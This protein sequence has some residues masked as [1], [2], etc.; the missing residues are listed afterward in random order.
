MADSRCGC[1]VLVCVGECCSLAVLQLEVCTAN[2]VFRSCNSSCYVIA[3]LRNGNGVRR[4]GFC[5]VLRGFCLRED[6]LGRTSISC[7][8]D[9]IC[10]G[11]NRSFIIDSLINTRRKRLLRDCTDNGSSCIVLVGEGYGNGAVNQNICTRKDECQRIWNSGDGNVVGLQGRIVGGVAWVVERH[12]GRAD[13]QRRQ[14]ND[15]ARLR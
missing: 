2:I 7:S 11:N 6:Y 13:L 8:N 5:W 14:G 3:I 10:V 1:F 15:I 4:T 9:T 12:G